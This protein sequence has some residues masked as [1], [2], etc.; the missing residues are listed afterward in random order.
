MQEFLARVSHALINR[1]RLS[2]DLRKMGIKTF[3]DEGGHKRARDQHRS[4]SGGD[5]EGSA[6]KRRRPRKKDRHETNGGRERKCDQPRPEQKELCQGCGRTGHSRDKC[7]L[8]THPDFN[9]NEKWADSAALRAIKARLQSPS[10]WV[11]SCRIDG[12]GYS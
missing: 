2:Q 1:L 11:L 8:S 6:S 7:M 3:V 5:Y 10:D 12:D 4:D 9:K